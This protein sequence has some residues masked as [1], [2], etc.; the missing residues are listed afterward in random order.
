MKT[1]LTITS[2][3]IVFTI[4]LL[5]A[6]PQVRSYIWD[7]IQVRIE[8]PVEVPYD[9]NE[10]PLA[11]LIRAE[12]DRAGIPEVITLALAHVES[13]KSLEPFSTRFEPHIYNNQ[14]ASNDFDRR[15]MSSSHGLLQVMGFHAQNC[16]LKHW[17]QLYQPQRNI[18]CGLKILND[19]LARY[20][21]VATQSD[22]LTKALGCYNGDAVTY[23][24][25]VKAAL[26]DIVVNNLK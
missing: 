13:G 20:K 12:S 4:G 26:A 3:T 19:C 9:P 5:L 15:A 17:S 24:L 6:I 21:S 25:K 22:R 11:D 14:K 10:L 2:I 16:G 8:V 1:L 23:P 18:R 7:Q